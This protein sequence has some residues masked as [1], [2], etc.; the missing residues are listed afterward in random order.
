MN[1]F[2][3]F[4]AIIGIVT[5]TLYDFSV[6]DIDG[7]N[8][9]FNQFK[10]KKV[11]IVNTASKSKYEN[12]YAGLEQLYQKYKDSLVIIVVPSNTFGNET[13][14]NGEIKKNV[15]SNYNT[16]FIITE[17]TVV[18]GEGQSALYAWLTDIKQNGMVNNPVN[19][20][21]Y[22]FLV[23]SSGT[24]IGVF[25]PSVDPMSDVVQNAILQ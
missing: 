16:H 18:A 20:D 3:L 14:E 22:K 6:T 9:T 21:F 2:F 19:G 13:G 1:K 10:G 11:M 8:I 5:T 12:Q 17:K 15:T 23:N 7:N 24:V 4:T 25:A